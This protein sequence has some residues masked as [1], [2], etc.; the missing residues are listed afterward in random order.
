MRTKFLFSH[1]FSLVYRY[2]NL[3]PPDFKFRKASEKLL[4]QRPMF[5]LFKILSPTKDL[6]ALAHTAGSRAGKKTKFPTKER[7]TQLFKYG[8]TTDN[9]ALLKALSEATV[10]IEV[11][12]LQ[13]YR[14]SF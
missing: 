5:P 10:C 8:W 6:K 14:L 3:Q 13:P 12:I 1:V 2:C 7:E 9:G 11:A 4:Q